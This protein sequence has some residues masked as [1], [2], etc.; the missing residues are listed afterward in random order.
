MLRKLRRKISFARA[1]V[2]L[3]S[4]ASLLVA[5]PM[6]ALPA[7]SFAQGPSAMPNQAASGT[8]APTPP[9]TTDTGPAATPYQATSPGAQGYADPSSPS[10]ASQ[11][12]TD[13]TNAQMTP[14]QGAQTTT[15]NVASTP[16]A[17][18]IRPIGNTDAAQP[19]DPPAQGVQPAAA[20]QSTRSA[21]S[22]PAPSTQPSGYSMSFTKTAPATVNEGQTITYTFTLTN[23]SSTM[24]LPPAEI[25]D[26][27]LT[28]PLPSQLSTMTDGP[29]VTITPTNGATIRNC[30]TSIGSTFSCTIDDFK[31]GTI[32]TITFSAVV[33]SGTTGQ[34][35]TNTAT[36]SSAPVGLTS[37]APETAQAQTLVNGQG[38]SAPLTQTG[39]QLSH[40]ISQ[41]GGLNPNQL[42]LA[43]TN[44]SPL[45]G[46]AP[47]GHLVA[48]P[49]P[50]T[51]NQ[52]L[53]LEQE[54]GK[55]IQDIALCTLD[56]LT[57]VVPGSGLI[58][59]VHDV[60]TAVQQG[61]TLYALVQ[62][63]KNPDKQYQF[64]LT[65]IPGESC[66]EVFSSTFLGPYNPNVIP[67]GVKPPVPVGTP[68]P[69]GQTTNPSGGGGGA[70]SIDWLDAL[71]KAL[72]PLAS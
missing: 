45:Q 35:I 48:I 41:P 34:T 23:T 10:G 51:L 11:L 5:I 27:T 39:Q 59:T 71:L 65:L 62:D 17:T 57:F 1:R 31:P 26:L 36:T 19:G 28:D 66:S 40:Q 55:P 44:P 50:L 54:E 69:N 61:D 32:V 29:H 20:S 7:A 14:A 9:T 56:T 72:A 42:Q 49:Q 4:A 15:P 67:P 37:I 13:Q 46:A 2:V 60:V 52:I 64:A 30:A 68:S 3:I 70:G 53:K 58:A 47:G 38:S 8:V 43:G 24:V 21:A 6:F 25:H 22:T 12:P 33:A 63:P 16:S 18:P